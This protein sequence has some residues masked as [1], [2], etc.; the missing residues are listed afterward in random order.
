[1]KATMTRRLAALEVAR[2]TGGPTFHVIECDPEASLEQAI[3]ETGIS[4]GPIAYFMLL[5]RYDE[6]SQGMPA[7]LITR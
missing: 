5:P 2:P 4:P 3:S 7:R 6:A 1:M